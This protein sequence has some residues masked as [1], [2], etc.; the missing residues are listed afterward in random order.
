MNTAT[1][2]ELRYNFPSVEKA[3]RKG[4]VTITRKGKAIATLHALQM[5]KIHLPKN[6]GVNTKHVLTWEDFC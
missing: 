3:A 5:K 1:V 2:S 6:F 4:P